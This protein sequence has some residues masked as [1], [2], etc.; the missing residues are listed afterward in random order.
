MVGRRSRQK[1]VFKK[2][3]MYVEISGNLIK[4]NSEM[5]AR[6]K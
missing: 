5:K 6:E 2:D 1:N 3:T 4:Y